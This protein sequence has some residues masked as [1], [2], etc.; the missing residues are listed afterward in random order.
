MS[1]RKPH[2]PIVRAESSWDEIT[3]TRLSG[4]KL[5]LELSPRRRSYPTQD[6]VVPWQTVLPGSLMR[7]QA[8][9]SLILASTR[10]L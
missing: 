8:E 6:A 10:R 5:Y 9:A 3:V 1:I 7:N 2:I 4:A